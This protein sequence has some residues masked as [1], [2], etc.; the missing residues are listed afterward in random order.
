MIH[1]HLTAVVS[2][3]E[4]ELVPL[5]TLLCGVETVAFADNKLA[6]RLKDDIT[7]SNYHTILRALHRNSSVGAVYYV[8]SRFTPHQEI[9]M[10]VGEDGVPLQL[11]N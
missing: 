1:R 6:I 9:L 10:M 8:S 2:A 5:L 11:G 3:N 7:E 4:A